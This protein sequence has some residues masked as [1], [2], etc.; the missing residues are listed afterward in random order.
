MRPLVSAELPVRAGM[1]CSKAETPSHRG[2]LV[3]YWLVCMHA[4]ATLS[5]R[6]LFASHSQL[7]VKLSVF[8]FVHRNLNLYVTVNI[9]GVIY[10]K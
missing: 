2:C 8:E 7:P 3:H 5:L 9:C 1:P 10:V 4:D 6:S